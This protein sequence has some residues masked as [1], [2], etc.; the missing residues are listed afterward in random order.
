MF[1]AVALTIRIADMARWYH[2]ARMIDIE[3]MGRDIL[4]ELE[5]AWNDASGERFG[6]PFSADAE[7]VDIRGEHHRGQEAIA[8]GHQGIFDTI[9]LG[10][11]VRFQLIQA[12]TL[13]ETIVLLHSTADLETPSGPLAGRQPSIQSIV[14]RREGTEWKVASFH[15]TLRAGA[16]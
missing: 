12:H 16:R 6:R 1:S 5:A 15:N 2:R 10:S 13:A 7:F 3:S 14:L 8:R 4:Q 9:Y 11:R